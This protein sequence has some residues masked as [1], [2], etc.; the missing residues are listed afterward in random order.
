MYIPRLSIYK[1]Q[2]FHGIVNIYFCGPK[3]KR[4]NKSSALS[5]TSDES[6]TMGLLA[7]HCNA[8][9]KVS[10][11][12]YKPSGLNGHTIQRPIFFSGIYLIYFDLFCVWKQIYTCI[13]AKRLGGKRFALAYNVSV[14]G[15]RNSN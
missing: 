6:Y 9:K 5:V 14:F 2:K 15:P 11:Y 10:K 3:K 12:R 4:N 7:R 1:M 13:W 8:F